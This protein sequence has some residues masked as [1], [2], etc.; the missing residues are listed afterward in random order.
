MG[1]KASIICVRIRNHQCANPSATQHT[2]PQ[3]AAAAQPQN[4]LQA[5][6]RVPQHDRN[7]AAGSSC[8]VFTCSPAESMPIGPEQEVVPLAEGDAQSPQRALD[9]RTLDVAMVRNA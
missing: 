2:P 4:A 3:L 6:A 1:I 9:P 8:G 5:P 7:T